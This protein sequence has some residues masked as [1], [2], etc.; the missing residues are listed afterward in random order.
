M[1]W[2]SKDAKKHCKDC[3]PSK[4]VT[5]ANSVLKKCKADP[6]ATDCEGRA[7]RIANARAKMEES[8]MER[9]SGDD[10]IAL[11][12]AD[13]EKELSNNKNDDEEEDETSID[14]R[15]SSL[16]EAVANDDEVD[17]DLRIEI[18]E[19]LES[20]EVD[21]DNLEEL[22]TYYQGHDNEE[23]GFDKSALETW[24][25]PTKRKDVPKSHFFW[26]EK[27]KYPYRN[28]DGSVNCA[29]VLAAWKMAHGA[30][31]GKKAPSW[32]ISKIKPHRDECIKKDDKKKK[33]EDTDRKISN[34]E[35]YHLFA[36]SETPI[37]LEQ[38]DGK[39]ISTVHMLKTGKFE[40][41]WWGV[42]EFDRKVFGTM[43]KN[44]KDGVP[45]GKIA[46]DFRHMPERGAAAWVN[47]VFEKLKGKNGA[48]LFFEVEWTP[49]GQL[50]VEEKSFLFT[51]IEFSESY[52]DNQTGKI[53]GPTI[54]GGALTNRP[55]IKGLKPIAMSDDGSEI[56]EFDE[57]E[58][59]D[60]DMRTL[61]EIQEE[62]KTLNE[63]I[64]ELKKAMGETPKPEHTDKLTE[65]STKLSEAI[66]ELDKLS[67]TVGNTE[68]IKELENKLKENEEKVAS[69]TESHQKL[70]TER[71]R[72][73][74]VAYEESVKTKMKEFK[75]VGV[76]PAMCQVA[77]EILL[78]DSA[79][80]I[81]VK[82]FEERPV[83]DGNGQTERVET[84]ISFMQVV[85]KIFLALPDE[86]KVDTR[87]HG[88]S[89]TQ[90]D[91]SN[92]LDI[93]G[94]EKYAK[95]H[96]LSFDDAL[97]ELDKQGKLSHD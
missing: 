73:R 49:N 72:E 59:V 87:V 97:I 51:S 41:P 43:I 42:L 80:S 67:K 20:D 18:V 26:P 9:L 19:F 22:E 16:M 54:L 30:R 58:E 38:K 47:K 36:S 8:I 29:G 13:L 79:D 62:I 86:A 33:N 60:D 45:Y 53:Y 28:K 55:F 93:D 34:K 69:L 4:W 24:K 81:Q 74:R 32:L 15:I 27:K 25:A 48:D 96:N 3:N 14:E 71:K 17:A 85:D 66:T 5:I 52:K 70:L 65:L 2:T 1:P 77:E 31:S 11:A 10:L 94:V 50:A 35:T 46:L 44:F 68:H 12:F 90:S 82:I 21:E 83:K 40:H 61:K 63:A 56:L 64:G 39:T 92:R 75:D 89:P 7:I 91:M 88:K 95:E 84:N 23:E 6:K 78:S 57:I 37:T 76:P